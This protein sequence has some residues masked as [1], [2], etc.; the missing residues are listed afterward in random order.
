MAFGWCE[1]SCF[2]SAQVQAMPPKKVFL[3]EPAHLDR[4]L[5]VAL[6]VGSLVDRLLGNCFFMLPQPD[7]AWV[8]ENLEDVEIKG[9]LLAPR[10][11]ATLPADREIALALYRQVR[12][13]VAS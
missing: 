7:A 5:R 9:P 3:T 13:F 11:D 2:L 12:S 10:T 6:R 8:D 4:A 1:R